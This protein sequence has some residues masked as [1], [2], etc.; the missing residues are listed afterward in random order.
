MQAKIEGNR[1]LGGMVVGKEI[2]KLKRNSYPISQV[3]W[4]RFLEDVKGTGERW[5]FRLG[6]GLNCKIDDLI[7]V[8]GTARCLNIFHLYFNVGREFSERKVERKIVLRWK[9]QYRCQF[10]LKPIRQLPCF[11]FKLSYWCVCILIALFTF[12]QLC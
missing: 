10:K 7:L 5:G 11:P 8:I 2:R 4:V 9:V 1:E 6:E 3:K 12:N